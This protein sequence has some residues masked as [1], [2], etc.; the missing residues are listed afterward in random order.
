MA[1]DRSWAPKIPSEQVPHPLLETLP[2]TSAS[3][4]RSPGRDKGA[5][6]DLTNSVTPL[7]PVCDPTC[8][9]TG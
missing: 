8:A 4:S 1:P 7:T 5:G 2:L 3:V 6:D 9:G